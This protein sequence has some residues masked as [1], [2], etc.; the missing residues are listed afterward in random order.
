MFN[1]SSDVTTNVIILMVAWSG[2]LTCVVGWLWWRQE[3]F[4]VNYDVTVRNLAQFAEDVQR[5]I[6]VL[7]VKSKTTEDKVQDLQNRA[8][9]SL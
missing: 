4:T 1:I 6:N 7:Q 2:L 9:S 3:A 5:N 8:K